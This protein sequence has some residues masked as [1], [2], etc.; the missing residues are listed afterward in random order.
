MTTETTTTTTTT[1]TTG[2]IDASQLAQLGKRA[3]ALAKLTRT[4]IRA[5]GPGP[6]LKYA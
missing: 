6:S 1:T 4:G 3:D 5:G 2:K